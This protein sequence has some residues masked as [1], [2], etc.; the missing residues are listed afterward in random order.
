MVLVTR[1]FSSQQEYVLRKGRVP[2]KKCNNVLR[3]NLIENLCKQVENLVYNKS[4]FNFNNNF[5]IIIFFFIITIQ[6]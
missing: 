2:F 1:Q 5:L 4:I 6:I 3:K